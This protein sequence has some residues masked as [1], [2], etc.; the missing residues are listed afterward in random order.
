M[1]LHGLAAHRFGRAAPK[2]LS[3]LCREDAPFMAQRV[4]AISR[5]HIDT[6]RIVRFVF[7]SLRRWLASGIRKGWE[8]RPLIPECIGGDTLPGPS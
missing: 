1:M 5:D 6:R 8:R 2:N 7:S 3:M 4:P